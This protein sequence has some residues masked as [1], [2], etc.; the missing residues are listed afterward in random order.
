MINDSYYRTART[1]LRKSL[2]FTTYYWAAHLVVSS[3]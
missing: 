2:S 3:S 1:L